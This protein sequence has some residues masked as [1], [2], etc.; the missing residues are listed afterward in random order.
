MLPQPTRIPPNLASRFLSEYTHN[1]PEHTSSLFHCFHQKISVFILTKS[2]R[3]FL[4]REKF[5]LQIKSLS[6]H[7][8]IAFYTVL[9]YFITL[10][11]TVLAL[12]QSRNSI[13]Q[14]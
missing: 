5:L 11:I 4:F 9:V 12:P 8:C 7:I 2:I 1:I 14:S 13:H 6:L 10:G 3:D